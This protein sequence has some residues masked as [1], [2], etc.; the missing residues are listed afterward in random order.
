MITL[1]GVVLTVGTASAQRP[2]LAEWKKRRMGLDRKLVVDEFRIYYSLNGEDALPDV[3]DVNRNSI[4]DRIDNIALQLVTARKLF[5]DVLKLRHPLQGPR[6]KDQAKFIDVHVGSIPFEAGGAKINGAAGDAVVNYYRPDDPESGIRVLTMDIMKTLPARNG[7]PAH[8]LFH[9]FQYGYSMF[10]VGW[11]EEGTARWSEFVLG[12][13]SG[14]PKGLPKTQDDLAKLFTMKYEAEG[15]WSLLAWET[16]KT[17]R[18]KIPLALR[19][20]RY[21][22]TREP[23]IRDIEFR[24]AVLL[25]DLLE[26]LDEAD[27]KVTT[28]LKL[29]PYKWK[30]AIQRRPENNPHIWS[31]VVEVARKHSRRSAAIRTM[32]KS[33]PT[34]DESP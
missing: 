8:E 31:A 2:K 10:K 22:G 18:M 23:V 28:E 12:E 19:K 20:A 26:A 34:A 6:Y 32:L 24:G 7:T 25:K 11:Y 29:E 17:G 1:V 5:V 4:P 3:A 13:G 14:N 27:D 9:L 16:D 30:E 15:F 33:V 21:I